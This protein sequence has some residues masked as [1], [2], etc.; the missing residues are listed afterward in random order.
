MLTRLFTAVFFAFAVLVVRVEAKT[1]T[2]RAVVVKVIDGDTVSVRLLNMH[3][4]FE[5]QSIRIDGVDTAELRKT[6]SCANE[7]DYSLRAKSFLETL[8]PVGTRVVVIRNTSKRD[9]YEG[10]IL[11]DIYLK[12]KSVAQ[13]LKKNGLARSYDGGKKSSWCL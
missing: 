6:P 7:K 11:S 2:L 8:L 10:R 5:F 13:L 1:F 12:R 4:A 9:K 3:P